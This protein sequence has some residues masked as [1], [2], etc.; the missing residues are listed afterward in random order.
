MCI[1]ISNSCHLE[2]TVYRNI[3]TASDAPKTLNYIIQNIFKKKSNYIMFSYPT[4][5]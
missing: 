5:E 1:Y 4:V 2:H 3:S